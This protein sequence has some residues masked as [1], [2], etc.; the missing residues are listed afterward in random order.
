MKRNKTNKYLLRRVGAI[1]FI[2]LLIILIFIIISSITKKEN[3]EE[4][5]ILLDNEL[6]TLENEVFVQ[7]DIIYVSK[8]DIKNMFD[9]NILYIEEEQEIVT[10]FNKHIALLKVGETYMFVN[11]TVVSLKGELKEI[12]GEIYIPITD[13]E[14]V[15][16][17]EIEYLSETKRAI[18]DFITKEKKQ[19]ITLKNVN[20]KNEMGLF[21]KTIEKIKR[22][23]YVIVLETVGEYK[24]IRTP[25]GNIGYVKENKTSDETILRESMI[26]EEP[27]NDINSLVMLKNSKNVSSILSTYSER[28]EVIKEAYSEVINNGYKGIN[29]NFEKIDDL[30][31][32]YRLI[33]EITP[34]FKEAGLVVAVTLN[35][36][37]DIEGLEK[38][39]N[40][41][42]EE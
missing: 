39:V 21:S 38:I 1:I 9:E 19:S 22:S 8:S 10:T 28:N 24:K 3:Y 29:I 7:N 18:I 27:E 35:D 25:L 16:D 12:S 33:I 20:V 2:L 41:I 15:Y 14:I 11:D 32:F 37:L 5:S 42:I 26:D 40:Y 4:I 31:S 30:V 17:I 23:E 13:L 36:S 6:V 34:R